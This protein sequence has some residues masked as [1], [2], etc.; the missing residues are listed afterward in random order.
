[1]P[2]ITRLNIEPENWIKLPTQ[3]SRVFNCA[4]GLERTITASC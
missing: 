2:I 1:Q 3:F 4:L